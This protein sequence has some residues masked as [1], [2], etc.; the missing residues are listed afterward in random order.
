MQA[1]R[2]LNIADPDTPT[3]AEITRHT[4]EHLNYE[5]RVVGVE[6]LAYPPKIGRSPWSVPRPFIVDCQAAL[7]LGYAPITTYAD[8]I[9]ATCDWLVRDAVNGDWKERYPVLASYPRNLFDYAAEDAYFKTSD[10][11]SRPPSRPFL[12]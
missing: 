12:T 8:A 3:V 5:G 10:Y 11:E 7:D 1:S 6:D 4:V 9:G 2:I